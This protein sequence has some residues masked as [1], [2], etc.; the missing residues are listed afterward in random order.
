MPDAMLQMLYF[1]NPGLQDQINK[2]IT[3]A[4]NAQQYKNN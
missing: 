3:I 4:R 2:L 1:N